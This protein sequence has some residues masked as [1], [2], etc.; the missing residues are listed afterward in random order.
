MRATQLITEAA[1]T[2]MS[3]DGFYKAKTPASSDSD[4]HVMAGDKNQSAMM[5]TKPATRQTVASLSNYI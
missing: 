4:I 2:R 1:I 3:F 5:A